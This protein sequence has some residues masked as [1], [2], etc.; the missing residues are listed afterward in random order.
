MWWNPSA[1]PASVGADRL[2]V[3]LIEEDGI[4]F[5]GIPHDE[6]L[7]LKVS[8]HHWDEFV[9]PETV[10][11]TV[12]EADVERVRAW[13]HRR[14]PAADGGLRHAEVCLYTDTPDGI[15]VIDR[16]PA[17]PGVAFASA[18]SGTG[19]KFAPVV[20]SILADLVLDGTTSFPIDRFRADRFS[21]SHAAGG[22][23]S[24]A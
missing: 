6:E 23:R 20:G 4:A 1:P 15:F 14:M 2:P 7:G 22:P 10:D 9:D 11:R 17:A 24:G 18:C 16:H 8:I 3:W 13:I 12:A 21:A 19:F 5:Y